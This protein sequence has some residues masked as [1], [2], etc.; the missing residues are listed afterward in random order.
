MDRDFGGQK[1]EGA[2]IRFCS[3]LA[4]NLSLTEVSGCANLMGNGWISCNFYGVHCQRLLMMM[5]QYDR[6]SMGNVELSCVEG[7][8]LQAKNCT[9]T[10]GSLKEVLIQRS[11]FLHCD[12][13]CMELVNVRLVKIVFSGCVFD[14]I[15]PEHVR[16]EEVLFQKCRFLSRIAAESWGYTLQNCIFDC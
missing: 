8:K 1:N 11:T 6:C 9:F 5:E 16:M 10:G 15:R 2:D 3:V 14:R 12:F 4:S 7:E 13:R